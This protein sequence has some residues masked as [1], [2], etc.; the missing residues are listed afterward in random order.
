VEMSVSPVSS[1]ESSATSS[2][3][4]RRPRRPVEILG[5]A[6][7]IHDVDEASSDGTIQPA[8][9]RRRHPRYPRYSHAP[10]YDPRISMM[11]AQHQLDL[12]D[13]TARQSPY[14]EP[15][16]RSRTGTAYRFMPSRTPFPPSNSHL[17][18]VVILPSSSSRPHRVQRQYPRRYYYN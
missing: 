16:S 6:N 2:G 4:E 9:R 8:N 14:F 1:R 12:I 11:F 7:A 5:S 10:E 3:G 18:S 15:A 17:P 13:V